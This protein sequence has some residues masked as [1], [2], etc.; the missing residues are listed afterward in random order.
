MSL[1]QSY[2]FLNKHHSMQPGTTT[3]QSGGGYQSK[4]DKIKNTTHFNSTIKEVTGENFF[5]KYGEN[6]RDGSAQG[7]R[8][9]VQEYT[10]DQGAKVI[11]FC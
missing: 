11:C 6:F 4:V 7:N 8:N 5:T 3:A 2:K 10:I 9:A 1:N